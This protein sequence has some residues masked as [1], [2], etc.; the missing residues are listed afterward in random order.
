MSYAARDQ[1]DADTR[2]PVRTA[3][4]W[5][6]WLHRFRPAEAQH[7]TPVILGHGLMMNRWCWS[8]SRHG[9]LPRALAERGHDVWVA[10]YRGSG[11]SRPPE[12]TPRL[13]T[14]QDHVDQDLPA[15]IDFVRDATQSNDVHWVGHSMGGMVAYMHACRARHRADINRLVTIG[16]PVGFTHV[17]GIIGPLGGPARHALRRLDHVWVRP[18]LLL[19]LPFV[20]LVPRIALRISGSSEHLNLKERLALTALAF[21]NS[22]SDLCAW[23]MDRW[24]RNEMLCPREIASVSG[25]GF[26]DLDVPTLIVAGQR[27]LLAPPGAVRRAFDETEGIAAAYKLFGDPEQ[28]PEDAGPALGHA[29]LISG[30]VAMQHV[31]PLVA[32]WLEAPEPRVERAT[33]RAACAPSAHRSPAP[34]TPMDAAALEP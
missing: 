30:E 9:S 12:G 8:L 15:L 19:T 4:G 33:M 28:A 10:E 3:D 29:D 21:E 6:I 24:L 18:L 14:F 20:A 7:G 32:E 16:S 31:L 27:D 22:S 2:H 13:W 17:R 25:G 34:T 1:I 23:F 5:T 11:M 26:A